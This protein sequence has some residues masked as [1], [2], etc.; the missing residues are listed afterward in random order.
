MLRTVLSRLAPAAL[1]LETSAMAD[2]GSST[3]EALSAAR[4]AR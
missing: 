4:P 2:A 3:D 1:L